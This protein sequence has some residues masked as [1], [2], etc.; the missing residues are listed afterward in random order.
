M[1]NYRIKEEYF[2]VNF[3]VNKIIAVIKKDKFQNKVN[4]NVTV[5]F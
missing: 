5:V 2:A 4:H 1:S 3:N